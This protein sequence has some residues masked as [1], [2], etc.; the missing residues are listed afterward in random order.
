MKD[1]NTIIKDRILGGIS[2]EDDKRLQK[3][4]EQSPRH[5]DAFERFMRESG[6]KTCYRVYS[7]IDED[8]AWKEFKRIN[9]FRNWKS[10]LRS[11][12][13]YAA[14]VLLPLLVIASFWYFSG[15]DNPRLTTDNRVMSTVASHRTPCD[16]ATSRSQSNARHLINRGPA[17]WLSHI[18]PAV[19]ALNDT[20]VVSPGVDV[21]VAQTRAA[22]GRQERWITLEDGTVVH[23]NH[24]SSL[25]YP[26][27]FD[28]DNRTVRLEGEGYFVVAKDKKRPFYVMTTSGIVKEYGTSFNVNTY[29]PGFTKVVLVEGSISLKSN[30]GEET[31]IRPGELAVVSASSPKAVIS[32]VDVM[33]YVA[34]NS[35]RYVFMD[36]SLEQLMNVIAYWYGLNVH[37][38]VKTDRDKHFTG[39]IDRGESLQV[40]LNAL[41]KLT[42]LQITVTPDRD[43]IIENK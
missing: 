40:L 17:L 4:L 1:I 34:W 27:H 22:S 14:I 28:T 19:S 35:G 12:G 43:L 11:V 18:H 10:I 7:G 21:I 3:W 24:S 16:S 26:A 23:L 36:T 29:T 6:L 32:Q 31:M 9:R 39:D 41:R 8:E 38:E 33:P 2:E 30:E 37:F 13:Y 15:G 25:I 5:R 42:D 20:D